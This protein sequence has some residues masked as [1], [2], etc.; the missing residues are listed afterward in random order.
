MEKTNSPTLKRSLTLMPVIF[1][2]LAFMA[3]KTFFST[4]GVAV[5][6]TNGMMPTAYA[7]ALVVMLFTAYSYAQL[8][9]AFPNAGAAYTFTQKS[10][11]PYIGFIVGWTIIID[12][13][14]SPMISSLILGISLKA[15]FP[16]IPMFVWIILFI[17]FI[18]IVNIL[19]IKLAAKLNTYMLLFQIILFGLFFIL[20]IK[21]LLAGKGAGILFSTNPFYDS[22]INVSAFLSVVPILCFSFLGFDAVTTLSEETK[23]PTRTLPKAIYLI[24]LI[25]GFLF[26]A[27]SYFAQLI[28][29]DFQ[30]FKNPES[31][32]LEIA[33]YIGGHIFSSFFVVVGLTATTASA[34]ASGTSASR[35]LYSMGRE[36]VLPK[37]IFGYLSQKYRTPVVNILIIGVIS[38]SALFLNL[39]TAISLISF[40]ALF[41]FFFVNL[42]VVAHYFFRKE[43]RSFKETIQYLMIPLIGAALIGLFFIKLDKHSLLLGGTWLLIGVIFLLNLTKMFRQPPPELSFKEAQL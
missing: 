26:I 40:G 20:T 12:Y 8:V 14:L 9:K 7:L 4:Y 15:Y 1:F 10:I 28:F 34:I 11:N 19:G 24:T 23:N 33:M 2:G 29:P 22:K 38:L 6:S 16:F 3:P 18:T 30:S 5:H 37:K 36:N 39:T 35:I 43:Q 31:A 41:A 13:L 32:Y 17:I 42:S 25:G 27:G 21:G